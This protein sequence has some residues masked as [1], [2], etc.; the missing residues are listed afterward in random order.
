M[1][2]SAILLCQKATNMLSLTGER[3]LLQSAVSLLALVPIVAGFLGLAKGIQAFDAQAEVSR[4]GDSH[5][6]YLSGL[7]LATGLGYWS[8]VSDI[9]TQRVRFRLLTA[10]VIT[11]GFGRLYAA[12]L[13]G[14]PTS[15]MVVG[16][17]MELVVAPSLALWRERIDQRCGASAQN[18]APVLNSQ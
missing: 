15:E 18:N 4:S 11:G 17:A 10:L 14:L 3:R 9:E 1:R 12:M 2:V 7:M 13:F 16:L 5:I 8:T 6:R